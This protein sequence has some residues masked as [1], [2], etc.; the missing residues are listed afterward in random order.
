MKTFN[1]IGILVENLGYAIVALIIVV[2]ALGNYSFTTQPAA[3]S[4][5]DLMN[6]TRNDTTSSTS[7]RTQS[8]VVDDKNPQIITVSPEGIVSVVNLPH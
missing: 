5:S 2:A 1:L 3:H 6:V 8:F 4:E 7:T